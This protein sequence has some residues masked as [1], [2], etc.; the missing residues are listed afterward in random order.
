MWCEM[1]TKNDCASVL[2]L[3]VG[4]GGGGENMSQYLLLSTI[5]CAGTGTHSV[6]LK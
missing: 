3:E 4:G 2:F 1:I 5:Q 6:T